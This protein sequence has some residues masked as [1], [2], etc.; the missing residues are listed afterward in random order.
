MLYLLLQK[1]KLIYQLRNLILL[2]SILFHLY[3]QHIQFGR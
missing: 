1:V 2:M 3:I